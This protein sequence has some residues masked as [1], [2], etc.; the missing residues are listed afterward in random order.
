[1]LN[2]KKKTPRG[3][4]LRLFLF[5]FCTTFP[6]AHVE[7]LLRFCQAFQ[8]CLVAQFLSTSQ[9]LKLLRWMF[10][11]GA[12][13]QVFIEFMGIVVNFK[14]TKFGCVSSGGFFCANYIQLQPT[15][16]FYDQFC[17]FQSSFLDGSFYWE[18]TLDHAF[19]L[20][21]LFQASIMFLFALSIGKWFQAFSCHTGANNLVPKL[22]PETHSPKLK[23]TGESS[24]SKTLCCIAAHWSIDVS[25]FNMCNVQENLKGSKARP[26]KHIIYIYIHIR[27]GARFF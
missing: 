21:E 9:L 16:L 6:K 24:A 18:W 26:K 27:F 19:M 3:F 10:K 12:K 11:N 4:L 2:P 8:G 13:Q 22:D 7:T 17:Y 25:I 14:S 5:P 15:K 23:V 1:M 20:R